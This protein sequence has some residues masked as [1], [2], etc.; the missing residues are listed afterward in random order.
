MKRIHLYALSLLLLAGCAQGQSN[1]HSPAKLPS[2][3]PGEAVA[4]FAGGCFWALEEG[5][6]QLKGVHEVISGYAGGNVKNPTYEQVGTDETGHAESV[7]V[8]YDPKVISYSQLL[9][10]FFAGHDPTTLNRQGPDV[11]RDYRSV[12][13]Y[14]T[15]E[16]KAEIQEA[17][18]RTND[19]KHY[20]NRVVTEVTPITV[21]YPAENYH[22]NYFALH[23]NQPYIQS[24]S[25][26]K[27][28]KLRKAM[29]GHLKNNTA[30][31]MLE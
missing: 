31:T 17:I 21:F 18:K 19:S 25:L 7:Q 5:M 14:R 24:V 6:N 8:Y 28:E 10:A 4:T 1:D 3:K 30:L 13:F 22:Q 27:V 15:P 2:L 26:P 12:A 11:G 16:E 29:V 9:D 20:A 23:P